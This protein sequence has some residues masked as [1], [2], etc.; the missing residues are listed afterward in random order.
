MGC[1]N[2]YRSGGRALTKHTHTP[3]GEHHRARKAVHDP[4][5]RRAASPPSAAGRGGLAAG[6]A[7]AVHPIG[8]GPRYHFVARFCFGVAARASGPVRASQLGPS[9]LRRPSSAVACSDGGGWPASRGM[10]CRA[11]GRPLRAAARRAPDASVLVRADSPGAVGF[12]GRA[13][14]RRGAASLCRRLRA[15][16]WP[17]GPPAKGVRPVRPL[18]PSTHGAGPPARKPRH[19]AGES[20]PDF[21]CPRTM[22]LWQHEVQADT[23]EWSLH[24]RRIKMSMILCT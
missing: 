16:P 7:K 11:V 21:S 1:E 12:L 6:D 4:P 5:A 14:R 17:L 13:G 20:S 24:A 18:A 9:A 10:R 15:G 8:S 19:M 23:G 22:G 2:S 3:S